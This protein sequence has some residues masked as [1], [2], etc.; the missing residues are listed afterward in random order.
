MLG[1]RVTMDSPKAQSNQMQQGDRVQKRC[2]PTLTYTETLVISGLNI[3]LTRREIFRVV[4]I[5]KLKMKIESRT[6]FYQK[7]K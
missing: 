3:S 2:Y 5:V 4:Y 6:Y 7:E 1:L